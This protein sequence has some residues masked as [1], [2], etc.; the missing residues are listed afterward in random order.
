MNNGQLTGGAQVVQVAQE[1]QMGTACGARQ[2]S[3]NKPW[4]V[5]PAAP[6]ILI[7]F[8]YMAA[9]ARTGKVRE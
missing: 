5:A 6:K 7:L 9:G 4:P 1:A 3:W 8:Q 2:A